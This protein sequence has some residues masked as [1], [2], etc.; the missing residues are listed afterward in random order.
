MVSLT[1]FT[2]R[3]GFSTWDELDIDEIILHLRAPLTGAGIGMVHKYLATALLP[4]ILLTVIYI[5]GMKM[6][7]KFCQ[8]IYNRNCSDSQF[9]RGFQNAFL[10]Y[11]I[12]LHFPAICIDWIFPF[13]QMEQVC[14]EFFLIS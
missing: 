3:Y 9:S 8:E 13:F 7:I 1:G 2:A 10:K 11:C 4:A 5:L 6:I 12:Y 14:T